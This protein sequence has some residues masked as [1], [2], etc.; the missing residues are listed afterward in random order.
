M[1]QND[2]LPHRWS[3]GDHIVLRQVWAGRIWTA[4]PVTV[5]CD[6]AELVSVYMAPGTRFMRPAC[7]R[8]EYLR[9][10]ATRQWNLVADEWWPQHHL[11][12]SVPGEA[13]SVWT[14][15]ADPGW[16]HIGWKVDPQEP[17]HR[18]EIG[19]DTTDHVLDAVINPDLSSWEWKDE[20]EFAEAMDLDLFGENMGEQIRRETSRV[21][22]EA[23]I[24]RREQ[25]QQWATWRP[26]VG[27][28]I[29]NLVPGWEVV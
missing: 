13:C 18:T 6:S 16:K 14:M 23:L 20:G 2:S 19:F 22:S 4:L 26:P 12:T 29:P 11:W 27:W 1:Q 28:R 3:S 7:T 9:V 21:A 25:L 24:T 10:L 15:W 5:R 8:E 17:L